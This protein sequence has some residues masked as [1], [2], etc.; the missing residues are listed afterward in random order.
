[1]ASPVWRRATAEAKSLACAPSTVCGPGL[2]EASRAVGQRAG[3][4]DLGLHVG[5]L[6]GDRLEAGDRPAERGALAGVARG[7]VERRLGDADR[8]RG[9]ADPPAVE[10][11]QRDAHPLAG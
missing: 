4:L 6:V 2:L 5:E 11:G 3:R 1:M 7:D 8:L 10:R 9:D